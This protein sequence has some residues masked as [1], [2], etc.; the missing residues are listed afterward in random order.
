MIRYAQLNG[1]FSRHRWLRYALFFAV[2]LAVNSF[3][4]WQRSFADPDSF[5]HLKMALLLKERGFVADFPWLPFTTLAHAYADHHFLYHWAMVPFIAVFGPFVGAKAS[6]VFFAS[7]ALTAFYRLLRVCRAAAPLFF[8]ALLATSGTF[9]FRF[10]LVKATAPSLLILFLALAA[11]RERKPRLLFLL[12][13][14]YVWT[15][16]GWP[17][18]LVAAAA[19]ATGEFLS[20]SIFDGRTGIAWHGLSLRRPS[21]DII[22]NL[23]A[24]ASGLVAGVLVNPYFPR[25][26]QFYWEQ[27]FQIAIVGFRDRIGVGSEWYAYP[28][29][30]LFRAAGTVFVMAGVCLTIVAYVVLHRRQIKILSGAADPNERRNAALVFAAVLLTGLFLLLTL[31]SRRHV[32]YFV[33]FAFL[34]EALVLG[35]LWRWFDWQP[36]RTWIRTGSRSLVVWFVRLALLYFAVFFAFTMVRGV[37][38]VRKLYEK[39]YSWTRYQRAAEWLQTAAVGGEVVFHSDWDDFPMLFL[40]NDRQVYVNGLDPTFLYRQDPQLHDEY[41]EI[42]TGRMASGAAAAIRRDFN[43]RFVMIEKDHVAMR[44]A[45]AADRRAALVYDDAEVWIYDLSAL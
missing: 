1:F 6:A 27:I 32:E 25:N 10:D 18:L 31:R 24:I 41:V 36:L 8:A 5:Y 39:G 21:R 12:A 43:A 20:G 13:W 11:W 42:T 23:A 17:L 16:G 29:L 14:V 37:L 7:A 40:F 45:V 19:L 15:H 30:E 9:L 26:L 38:G 22:L 33:P 44:D 35:T 3:V 2:A 4:L 34:A 28:F